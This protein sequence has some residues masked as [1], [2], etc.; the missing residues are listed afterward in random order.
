MEILSS[1]FE[2]ISIAQEQGMLSSK[3]LE[4]R[5][6]EISEE[7]NVALNKYVAKVKAQGL[8]AK[9]HNEKIWDYKMNVYHND[10]SEQ[11]LIIHL[12]YPSI[13]ADIKERQD[14]RWEAT[15]YL[16]EFDTIPF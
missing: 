10:T 9:E 14:R 16:R 12:L 13:Y 7:K 8:P 15:A 1:S 4:D 11:R 6:A 3:A 2:E 5:F